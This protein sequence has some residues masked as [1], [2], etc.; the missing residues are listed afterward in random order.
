MHEKWIRWTS[1][2]TILMGVGEGLSNLHPHHT[3]FTIQELKHHVGLFILNGTAPTPKIEQCFACSTIY[4]T[5]GYNLVPNCIPNAYRRH[6][7]LK[8]FFTICNPQIDPFQKKVQPNFKVY[9]F[10]VHANKFFFEASEPGPRTY[11]DKQV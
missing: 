11:V 5:H 8:C 6:K 2:K 4:S 7:Y 10:F 9:A 1:I 3:S